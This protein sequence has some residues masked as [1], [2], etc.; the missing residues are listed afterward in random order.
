[1]VLQH[2]QQFH[3]RRGR[4]VA[5]FIEEERTPMGELE[6]SEPAFCRTRERTFFMSEKLGLEQG[7]RQRGA[8]H[9]DEGLIPSIGEFMECV[10]GEFLARTRFSLDEHGG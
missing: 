10:R 3:L 1:M 8:V 2:A 9:G 4:H 6:T 7:L 5:H